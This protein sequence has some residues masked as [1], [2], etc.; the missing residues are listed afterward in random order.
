MV[1]LTATY[2][3]NR[4]PT[5][6]LHG[7]APLHILQP[8]STLF[9]ILPCVF[10]CTCFVQVRSPT[11]TKLDDKAVRCVF[12]GYSSMSKGYRCYDHI[13]CHMYHS[14]DVTFLETVPFFSYSPSSLDPALELIVEEDFI[15]P[16]PLPILEFPP[17]SPNDSLPSIVTTDPS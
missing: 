11:R 8:T 9:P 4:T 1:V 6:V 14:L 10:G 7:K 3:I 16:S 13:T 17:L 2:L 5:R 15:P 12:L